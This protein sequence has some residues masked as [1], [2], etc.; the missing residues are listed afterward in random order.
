MEEKVVLID[1]DEIYADEIDEIERQEWGV[2]GESI[3]EEI[4]DNLVIKLAKYQEKIVGC[5]YAKV[6]GDLF[7]IEVIIVKPEYQH[8]HIGSLFMDYFLEYAKEH[9]LANMVG[10]GVCTYG[11]LNIEGIM[12]KYGFLEVFRV[13]NYWGARYPEASCK[14]CGQKPC[15]CTGVIFV[16]HLY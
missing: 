5:A 1:Y 9:K 4:S 2:N 11:R 12:K 14:S 16:K 6:I 3:R 7:Y 15:V 10:E 8:Q 13:K